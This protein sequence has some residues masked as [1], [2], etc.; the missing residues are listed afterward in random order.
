M[1]YISC[2][3]K[4]AKHQSRWET[5]APFVGFTNECSDCRTGYKKGKL[6]EFIGAVVGLV[7]VG[8]YISVDKDIIAWPT[9]LIASAILLILFTYAGPY[10]TKLIE[11]KKPYGNIMKRRMKSF[12]WGQ[13]FILIFAI[14]I[15]LANAITIKY[16]SNIET[17]CCAKEQIEKIQS[18]EKL[19][20][21]AKSQIDLLAATEGLY[22]SLLGLNVT[23]SIAILV[24][25]IL[26]LLFYLKIRD[27]LNKNSEKDA[28][29]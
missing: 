3:P 7:V 26:D 14:L 9:A 17:R 19:K 16:Y 12:L 27:A 23:I 15:L 24:Y 20:L 18:V 28:A 4:C 25:L 11:L 5:F 1:K 8:S 29:M 2:C 13:V 6:S 10:F 21:V 22:K